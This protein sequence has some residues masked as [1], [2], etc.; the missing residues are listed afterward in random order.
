MGSGHQLVA[1]EVRPWC[2]HAAGCCVHAPSHTGREQ[3]LAAWI[4]VASFCYYLLVWFHLNQM[5]VATWSCEDMSWMILAPFERGREWGLDPFAD[6]QERLRFLASAFWVCCSRG[7]ESWCR[8]DR[9][10]PSRTSPGCSSLA[11][12]AQPLTGCQG[13]HSPLANQE[14]ASKFAEASAPEASCVI[15]GHLLGQMG[16]Q[17]LA[18]PMSSLMTKSDI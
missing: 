8:S 4:W 7:K 12:A 13:C 11:V 15:Y 2:R 1:L 5:H 6:W 17:D 10:A 18:H 14:Y 16:F 9:G 3:S